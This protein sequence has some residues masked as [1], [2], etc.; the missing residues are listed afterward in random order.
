MRDRRSNATDGGLTRRQALGALASAGT[1]AVA[2]CNVGPLGGGVDPLW[3][4]TL[5]DA[6]G[7]APPAATDSHVLVGTQ[8]RSAYALD[9]ESG[10]RA[11]DVTT[12]GPIE[13][14]PAVPESGG[15]YHVH[16]T[17][18]D[19]YAVSAAGERLWHEEGTHRRASIG[20]TGSLLVDVD[21]HTETVRG[22]DAASGATRFERTARVYPFPALTESTALFP[23]STGDERYRLTAFDAADG[24]VRWATDPDSTPP[25]YAV[26][27]ELV[28][29]VSEAGVRAR[30]LDDGSV[31]WETTLDRDVYS[32]FGR[33]IWFGRDVY[34]QTDR[35]DEPDELVALDRADGTVRWSRSAGYELEDVAA[36][37]E[38]V[39][40]ASS[41]N[42]PDGGILV[43]VDAFGPDGDRRWRTTTDL[44]IGGTV[45]S[46]GRVGDVVFAA[47]DR[48][49]TALDS[50][51][52]ERRWR[53]DP[54]GRLHVRAAGDALFATARDGG[55]VA[56]LPVE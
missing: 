11:F 47:S 18:G 33:P 40:V 48:A 51:S 54:E 20:R 53:Y 43:R 3:E 24:T 27:G 9:V 13:T 17:D 39:Y 35:D 41:V 6:S 44:Q 46:F 12:G 32:Y 55:R 37:D 38:A 22:L 52:G 15:P 31:R 26:T 10:E 8:D 49:V 21:W 19:L 56:R 5:S 42:D 14:R 1:V 36:T 50:A 16:S 28:V 7:T 23:V 25:Y 2:G 29:T 45:A 30:H 34:L 4:Q